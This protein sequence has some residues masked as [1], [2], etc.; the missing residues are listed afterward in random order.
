VFQFPPPAPNGPPAT[1]TTAPWLLA[2]AI[3]S[4]ICGMLSLLLFGALCAG[5]FYPSGVFF[6]PNSENG[7]F[8]FGL[9]CGV[10]G[11]VLGHLAR[12]RRAALGS[13]GAMLARAGLVLSYGGT[14]LPLALLALIVLLFQLAGPF[15]IGP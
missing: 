10:I 4:L 8:A 6:A 1:A 9:T 11:V 3:A 2:S 12:T 5:I 7:V 13:R 15:P 14:L